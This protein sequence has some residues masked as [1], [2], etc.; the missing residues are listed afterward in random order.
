MTRFLIGLWI[1]TASLLMSHGTLAG[2][3]RSVIVSGSYERIPVALA[4]KVKDAQA[5]ETFYGDVISV[6]DIQGLNP[7]NIEQV[8]RSH[9]IETR[10]GEIFYPEEIE[11]LLTKPGT[12]E[13]APHTPD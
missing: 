10:G 7:R 11:Y 6:R 2:E 12:V 13:K 9:Q 8:L 5:L 3:K 4:K 1:F